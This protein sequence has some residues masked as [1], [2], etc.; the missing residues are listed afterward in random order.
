MTTHP[1][2]YQVL[3]HDFDALLDVLDFHLRSYHGLHLTTGLAELCHRDDGD[4]VR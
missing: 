3:P 4:F 2:I 1:G